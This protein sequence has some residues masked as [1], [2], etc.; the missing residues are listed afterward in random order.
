MKN[1]LI[2]QSGWDIANGDY[3]PDEPNYVKQHELAKKERKREITGIYVTL[4]LMAFGV[5]FFFML[6]ASKIKI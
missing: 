2:P 1:I 5:M 4:G 6:F 3:I